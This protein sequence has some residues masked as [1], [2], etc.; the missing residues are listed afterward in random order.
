VLVGIGP[1][2]D[3][4][5]DRVRSLGLEQHVHFAGF[6]QDMER[7]YN[8]VDVVV[9]SSLTEGMP[10]VVIESLL[11]QKPVIATDVGGTSQIIRDGANGTLVR[12]GHPEELARALILF[13]REPHRFL[14]MV[15]V[16]RKTIIEQF[17]FD[18]RSRRLE[19][20]Y[21]KVMNLRARP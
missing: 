5:Q 6:R 4:L 10:N 21:L 14:G 1:E 9:Q 13:M 7:I 17:G 2:H 3:A 20:I 16:G 11:M 8:G 18:T 12:P 19:Q 15:E